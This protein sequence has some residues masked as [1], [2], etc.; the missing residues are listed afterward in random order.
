M[1]FRENRPV[2]D[3]IPSR[4]YGSESLVES[5]ADF[6]FDQVNQLNWIQERQNNAD[7]AIAV[8]LYSG[9]IYQNLKRTEDFF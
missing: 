5:N 3:Y 2:T 9:E 4:V 1:N 7:T 6:N 8:L